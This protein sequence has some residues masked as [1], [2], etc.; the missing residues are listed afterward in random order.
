MTKMMMFFFF[1]ICLTYFFDLMN[2]FSKAEDLRSN[3]WLIK[4]RRT[5]SYENF[6]C[7]WHCI[8]FEHV[9]FSLALQRVDQAG[10]ACGSPDESRRH[11]VPRDS[12]AYCY[13][14][15]FSIS[16]S[17]YPRSALSKDG[18]LPEKIIAFKRCWDHANDS[19]SWKKRNPRVKET[20]LSLETGREHKDASIKG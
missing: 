7:D 12:W 14:Y 3:S 10:L 18:L 2:L 20:Y 15:L 4:N 5:T 1:F 6:K 13:K 19:L 9:E 17:V 11:A 16:S 8:W